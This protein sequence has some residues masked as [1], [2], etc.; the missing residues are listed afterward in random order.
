MYSVIFDMDGTLIDTQRVYVDAWEISGRKQGL[1]GLG[2]LVKYVCGMKHEDS[3]RF[4]KSNYPTLDTERFFAD[5]MPYAQENKNVSLLPGVIE[6]FEYLKGK[7]VRMAIA[8]SSPMHEI[9]ENVESLGI[10]KYFSALVSGDDVKRGKP[11][12]DIF[13]LAA[14]K[15]GTPPEKC[16]VFE[17]S[18]NGIRAGYD[19]GMRCF[20]VPNVAIFNDE[21]KSIS[22]GIIDS[23]DLAIKIFEEVEG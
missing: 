9:V 15:L 19:A 5:Y 23:I 14:E 10:A 21:I 20:G 12:P 13:L 2:S 22:F 18:P 16:Y 4:A 6:L 3:I 8:S 11:A 7:G 1:E 17:D